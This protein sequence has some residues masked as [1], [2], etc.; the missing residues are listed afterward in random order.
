M[1]KN[2]ACNKSEDQ[3]AKKDEDPGGGQQAGKEA[4][5]E[6]PKMTFIGVCGPVQN[7]P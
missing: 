4:D 7:A 6:V 2:H 3:D 5:E 1:K